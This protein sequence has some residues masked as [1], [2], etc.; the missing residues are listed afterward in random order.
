M[1]V[2]R[3]DNNIRKIVYKGYPT[4]QI[5]NWI[6]THDDVYVIT[7]FY[8]EVLEDGYISLNTF[9]A[10]NDV[11][12]VYSF[13]NKNWNDWDYK[14]GIDIVAGQKFYL[15][16]KIENSY[17]ATSG[18]NYHYFVITGKVNVCGNILSLLKNNDFWKITEYPSLYTFCHLFN[19]CKTI[20]HSKNLILP[21]FVSSHCYEYLF[22]ACEQLIDTPKFPAL[23]MQNR[24]YRGM[25]ANCFSLTTIEELPSTTLATSCYDSMFFECIQLTEAPKLPA[26]ILTDVCYNYMF[27]GCMN[28]KAIPELPATTLTSWCYQ[29]MFFGCTALTGSISFNIEQVASNCFN[30]IFDECYNISEL[31]YPKS[32]QNYQVFISMSGAPWFGATNATI[33]YDL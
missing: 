31:H 32:F 27:Y 22:Q 21:T 19:Q 23:I 9:G 29:R 6:K 13:D 11:S 16:A 3:K 30:D 8:F 4:Q 24:C 20:Q 5:T 33:Y 15:K 26:T 1:I 14:A 7:P 28:L 17:F 2:L 10:I 25:F 12:L 18:D